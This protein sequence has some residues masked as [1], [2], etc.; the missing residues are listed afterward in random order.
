MEDRLSSS[1]RL[2]R[3]AAWELLAQL[4]FRQSDFKAASE[5]ARKSLD[6]FLLVGDLSG[7]ET[8]ERLLGLV[9]LGQSD[10]SAAL[11]HFSM[12]WHLAELQRSRFPQD[13]TGQ[14]RAGYFARHSFVYEKL[15]ELHLAKGQPQEALRFAEMAKARAAQDLLS[16]LGIAEQEEP[17]EP[18][19]LTELLADWPADVAAVEF[20]LGAEH[21]RG[22]VIR[23]GKVRAFPLVE[24]QGQPIV[25][26]QLVARNARIDP[27][28]MTSRKV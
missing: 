25:T 21:S 5:Q 13:Q 19:E 26:R 12:A 14:S 15:V 11:K 17:V 23:E 27:L 20:F 10:Q 28:V 1:Q 9:A 3:A 18:R 2:T 16:S 22:F 8:I 4:S 6:L 24:S 7:V